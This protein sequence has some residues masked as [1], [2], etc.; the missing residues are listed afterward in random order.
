MWKL[1]NQHPGDDFLGQSAFALS[2]NDFG[3]LEY[4]YKDYYFNHNGDGKE[5]EPGL[6]CHTLTLVLRK[7]PVIEVI[8]LS[9]TSE[10]QLVRITAAGTGKVLR[11]GA[12][13]LLE[14]YS[15]DW[16]QPAVP[17]A[18]DVFELAPADGASI[19]LR[20]PTGAAGTSPA[21][22]RAPDGTLAMTAASDANWQAYPYG[23]SSYSLHH[24]PHSL[25]AE[26]G[27]VGAPLHNTPSDG[28]RWF[29]LPVS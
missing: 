26:D 22:V 7:E 16:S 23:D 27:K 28:R 12:D 11:R 3:V 14:L 4:K 25:L 24:G 2:T 13:G 19:Q 18:D 15:P 17:D 10:K 21:L 8:G 1:L 9:G 29:F 20:T 6:G 5:I